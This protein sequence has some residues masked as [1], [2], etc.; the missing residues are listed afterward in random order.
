MARRRRLV[1]AGW[2][3]LLVACAALYPSLRSD[4]SAPDYRVSGADSTRA[5]Q[6]LERYFPDAGSEQDVLVFYS[7]TLMAR[8]PSF[9]AVVQ[10]TLSL[11]ARQREVS[12]VVGPYQRGGLQVSRDGHAAIAALGVSG[13]ARELFSH[14]GQLQAL[15]ARSQSRSVQVWL[16]GYSPI[17]RDLMG[18]ENRDIERAELI[19]V[20]I[21]LVILLLAFGSLA[22]AVLPLLGAGA[23]LL[24]TYGVLAIL[25]R[26]FRF[27]VL[28]LT[29]VTMIGVGIG[30]DYAL[31]IVSRFREQLALAAPSEQGRDDHVARSVAVAIA[32]SGQM[33]MFSGM[34]VALSLASLFVLDAPIFREIAVGAVVVV[35][36]T[37]L[38]ALTLLP[39]TLAW[40]GPR[41]NRGSLSGRLQPADARA[42]SERPA[43][44]WA[45]WAETVMRHPLLAACGSAAV[46][47][48]LTVPVAGLRT[49]INLDFS[50]LHA[51][52]AGRAAQTLSS[53]F[54]AGALSPIEV[55]VLAA[56]GHPLPHLSRVQERQLAASL[57]GDSRVAALSVER[58][59]Q[60]ILATV[61]PAV[62]IDS[63]GATALVGR[64]RQELAPR[65]RALT[66]A[67]VLVGGTTAQF[68]DLSHETDDKLP[69][70]LALVLSL[71][72]VLLLIVFRSV[73]LPLKAA[74][75]NVLATGATMG[76]V[77]FVFQH[78]HGEHLLGFTT[79]G[80]I[81]VYLPLS[82]FALLFGL[83][84]DYEVFLIGRMRESW[85]Q[86][87]DNRLA[88]SSGLEH[89]GRPISA[90]AAIMVA[91]FGSFI[92]ANVLEIKQFGFALAVAIA[93]DATLVRLVLVPSLMRVLG[94]VNWWLPGSSRRAEEAAPRA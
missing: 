27:D 38:A 7:P 4:L 36:C 45:R 15:A 6:L 58:R 66:G 10:R 28:L 79:P 61:V 21:A 48:V 47:L 78:G 90:A 82:V 80:F 44:W 55:L 70:V 41:V 13:D 14:A 11:M 60:G 23:G 71:S 64:L 20:P 84:M 22:A 26:A 54:T 34:I 3:A 77:V 87:Y 18:I 40:L 51:S 67:T 42:A 74:L 92:T 5:A 76:M 46:L 2:A 35:V 63:E 37:L 68:V 50:A 72:L 49:G 39:A 1:L 57:S 53:S 88:V 94:S 62:S 24:L 83:S 65:I 31:F 25:A 30:I 32:T 16:T 69:L 81:Q 52:P 91:V 19:G 73:V 89:T 17:A 59:G 12:G 75:M 33:V 43:G 9:R 86:T 8:Q 56:P 85:R 93:L 29:I